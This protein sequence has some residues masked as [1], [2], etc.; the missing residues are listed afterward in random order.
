MPEDKTANTIPENM[1][2]LAPTPIFATSWDH[3][4][5]TVPSP[6][7]S[8]PLHASSPLGTQDDCDD[9]AFSLRQTQS[10]PIRPAP[11]FK[12]AARASAACANPLLRRRREDAQQQRRANFLRTVREKAEDKAWQ[13][14]DIE[15]QFLKTNWI[16]DMDRLSHDAPELSEADIEDAS[17]FQ[18]E[19]KAWQYG[20]VDEDMDADADGMVDEYAQ[21][22]ELEAMFA[23]YQ[24][25][26]QQ[27]QVRSPATRPISPSLSDDEYDDIFEELLS[28]KDI[29]EVMQT[30]QRADLAD[31]MDME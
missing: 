26:H 23:S 1:L 21:D 18:P 12:Y 15:G 10:S 30:H 8:S 6:L 20:D 25:Q 3:H 27:Q 16:A 28:A 19:M 5:P 17:S 14:R 7:S 11:T 31:E 13:R 2:S 4:R 29:D 22:A 24:Q 9:D